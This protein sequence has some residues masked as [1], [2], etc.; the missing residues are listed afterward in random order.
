MAL[1]IDDIG[2][3]NFR[4]RKYSFNADDAAESLIEAAEKAIRDKTEFI[5][6]CIMAAGA[7][8][9]ATINHERN[10]AVAAALKEVPPNYRTKRKAG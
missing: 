7:D 3:R 1:L 9:L 2:V 5:N 4:V 10:T 6:R 8:V